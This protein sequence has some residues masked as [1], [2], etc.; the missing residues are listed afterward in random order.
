MG[1]RPV[2]NSARNLIGWPRRPV[3]I[4]RKAARE[5]QD[6][7]GEV[8]HGVGI[9]TQIVERG[10]RLE[11]RDDPSPLVGNETERR[12]VHLALLIEGGDDGLADHRHDCSPA[13]A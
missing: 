11:R 4:S 7:V 13:P 12:D 1:E 5:D 3:T 2:E 8:G 10:R 6:V 9:G